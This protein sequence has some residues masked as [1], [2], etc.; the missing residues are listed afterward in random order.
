L[1]Q[2]EEEQ[3]QLTEQLEELLAYAGVQEEEAFREKAKKALEQKETEDKLQKGY[4]Q[5]VSSIPDENQRNK[6]INDI[7]NEKEDPSIEQDQLNQQIINIDQEK[8]ELLREAS[9]LKSELHQL[10]EAGT[11]EEQLQRFTSLK[12]KLNDQAKEWAMY[13]TSQ[14][15]IKKVKEIYEKQRQPNVIK[16]AQHIFARL[17]ANKYLYLFAPFG[18]ERFL[19][20]REDGQ[21]FNPGD[22]SRGT[23]ELLYLSIRLALAMEDSIKND[24]PLFLDETFVNIDKGRRVSVMNFLNELSKERQII[25]FT[26]HEHIKEEIRL[27]G[28]GDVLVHSLTR[29]C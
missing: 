1:L 23:C 20:E 9:H 14:Y 5:I 29:S 24:F 7:V 10:E 26:C 17:T 8:T 15:M 3:A 6:V 16:R 22:L 11:Y 4:L 18:E 19:V 13:K 27:I 25:L 2:V 21:R 28:T 12:E